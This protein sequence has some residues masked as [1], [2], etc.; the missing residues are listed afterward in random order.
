[1]TRETREERVKRLGV[2]VIPVLP[3]QAERPFDP[4]PVVAVCG[5]CGIDLHTAM[6]YVC[7]QASCPAGLGCGYRS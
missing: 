3:P 2:P 7:Q 5:Q 6:W 4:N 1:M